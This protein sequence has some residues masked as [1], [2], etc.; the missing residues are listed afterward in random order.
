[1]NKNL[2]TFYLLFFFLISSSNFSQENTFLLSTG[3]TE[4]YYPTYIGNGHFSI[5]SSQLG[6][7]PTESYM[8]NLYDEGENDIPRIAALPEWNEINYFD[9]KNWLNDSDI[10][11]ENISNYNQTLDMQNGLLHTSYS[12]NSS[13]NKITEFD[14]VAFVSRSNKNLAVIKFEFIANF[15]EEIKIIFPIKQRQKPQREDLATIDKY[16]KLKPTPDGEWPNFWYPGF[17]KVTEIDGIKN[18]YGA[19][20]WALV[21]SEGRNTK[22]GIASEIFSKNFEDVNYQTEILKTSTSVSTEFKFKTEVGKKYTF[23][24]LV[25]LVPEFET[26]N[27]LI[28]EAINILDNSREFGYEKLF[29]NHKSEWNNLWQTDIVIEGDND[30]QKIIHSMIFY[31]LCSAEANTNFGIPAMGL[32]TSGYFG[33]I[34]WDSDIYMFPPILLMH[35]EIAKSLVAF[36]YRTLQNAIENAK[37]NNYKG[38][39][40]PWESD[41]IGKET[42]PFFAYQNAVKENHI[43]GD[44]AF[45]QWQYF[46]A[47]KDTS[48]ISNFGAEIIRQTADFWLSRVTFNADKDRYEIHNIIS[49]SE[50]E[51]DVNNETYTNSIAKINLDLAVKIS[52]LLNLQINPE[53]KKVSDKMFIPFDS[54]KEFHPMYENAN[55]GEG[56]SKLWSS[57]V[58]LLD[59]PLR[60]PMTENTKRNDLVHA[61]KS[62]EVNGAGAMMGINFLSIIAAELGND[63]L[64][65]LTINKTLKGYLKPPFNVLSETHQNKSVN[66]LTGAGSFLQQVIFGYTGLRI[67]DEGIV[68]KYKPM[69]PEKV[70]KLTLKNFTI[71]NQKCDIVI[72]KNKLE[73]I[74]R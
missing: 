49:V 10:N 53:W 31:L 69:L 13:S 58:N 23:Y 22:V 7:K 6:T 21:Q 1:M 38:A 4:T 40:Y 51:K 74:V 54:E 34:F 33:H 19:K 42:T 52:E 72:E 65:N 26:D 67:T 56:T 29:V 66:F 36:R 30:L 15:S 28:H 9:G 18:N 44:V 73:K 43:V 55:A 46:C 37:I 25:S 64:L 17:V 14:I 68:E 47:T 48:Y 24:K 2:L 3:K 57:V 27:N 62:L 12:W 71:N 32:S 70:K 11:S 20:L 50:S 39:M 41:E 35:P 45:A 60:I 16:E 59:Y 8:I 63:S 61:V 5:S